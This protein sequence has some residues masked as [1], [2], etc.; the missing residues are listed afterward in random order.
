LD[1]GQV[2]EVPLPAHA[3]FSAGAASQLRVE[4]TTTAVTHKLMICEA[5]SSRRC[6]AQQQCNGFS[7]RPQQVQATRKTNDLEDLLQSGRAKFRHLGSP[8]R[9]VL[10][11]INMQ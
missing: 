7:L 4:A 5:S 6:N 2:P 1:A 8:W 11:D 10:D 3:R 9:A